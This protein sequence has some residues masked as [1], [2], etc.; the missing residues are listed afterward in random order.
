MIIDY[1]EVYKNKKRKLDVY[2]PTENESQSNDP[3]VRP[4]PVAAT[5]TSVSLGDTDESQSI[6]E[7]SK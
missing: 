3:I 6:S 2:N 1:Y 5:N 7:P 4:P